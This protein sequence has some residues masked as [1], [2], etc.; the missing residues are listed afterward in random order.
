MALQNVD[1]IALDPIDRELERLSGLLPEYQRLDM[2]RDIER[3][4]FARSVLEGMRQ[5]IVRRLEAAIG[6][7]NP[8]EALYSN[9]KFPDLDLDHLTVG[10]R[11]RLWHTDSTRVPVELSM[12]WATIEDITTRGLLIVK[13]DIEDRLRRIRRDEDVCQVSYD[14]FSRPNA[15]S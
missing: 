5:Q 12:E 6:A 15:N 4:S 8:S 14:G 2:Q 13:P 3:V 9:P 7:E 1:R 10:H 11:V